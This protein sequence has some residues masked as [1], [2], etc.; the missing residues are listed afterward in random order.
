MILATAADRPAIEAFLTRHI[1]TSMFPLSNL[2]VHGMAGG[3]PRAVR[4]WVRW[5]AGM[6]TDVLTVSDD[7]ILFPQCPTGPWGEVKIV[8]AGTLVRG[9]LGGGAQVASLRQALRLT[10]RGGIDTVEPLYRLP[11]T[12][13][14]MPDVTGFKLGPLADAPRKLVVDWRRA[15]LEEVLP[16]PGEDLSM[17]ADTEI[18][19]YIAADTHRVL[20]DKGVPVAMTGFNAVLPEAVQIGGVY[21]PPA[22]RNRGLARRALAMHLAETRENGVDHAIL[23]A[24]SAQAARAY[25]AL[26][27]ER[28]GDFSLVNFEKPQVIYG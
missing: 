19:G 14:Q 20:Y 10:D 11:L 27:F 7:G 5:R 21:T 25:E 18:A 12:D 3:H 4:F 16:M 26:G 22:L 8:L 9:F 15:Y 17:K 1:A 2:R 13:L 6:L 23:F 28:K 24:A